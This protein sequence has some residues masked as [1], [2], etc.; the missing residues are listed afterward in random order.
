MN[1]DQLKNLAD[2]QFER[3]AYTKTLRESIYARLTVAHNGGLFSITTSLIAFLAA[4][5]GDEIVVEDIYNNPIRVKRQ[6][7][8]EQ[9]KNQYVEIMLEWN[10]E[11]DKSN[12]IRRGEN[13]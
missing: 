7:L 8:L 4:M 12:R 2:A 3:S 9:A 10:T 1:P 6:Q 13:V 5:P 11:L